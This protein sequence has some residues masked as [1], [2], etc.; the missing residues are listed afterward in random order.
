MRLTPRA[1][2]SRSIAFLFSFKASR[3]S[4]RSLRY[5]E[6]SSCSLVILCRTGSRTSNVVLDTTLQQRCSSSGLMVSGEVVFLRP[7]GTKL[8]S[9]MSSY[10]TVRTGRRSSDTRHGGVFGVVLG[11]L[12][13]RLAGNTSASIWRIGVLGVGRDGLLPGVTVTGLWGFGD[14]ALLL[15]VG[16]VL[17]FSAAFCES[18]CG[19]PAKLGGMTI[20]VA[21]S[22][23]SGVE[24][25]CRSFVGCSAEP[26]EPSA[27]EEVAGLGS[28][29]T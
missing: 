6:L 15:A 16:P 4:R 24:S 11:S 26:G 13:G 23:A 27:S 7:R 8:P 28:S 17:A 21:S 25:S 2:V 18:S 14:L 5:L 3:F 20:T 10:D 19:C 29:A 1:L 12:A 22:R 9:A